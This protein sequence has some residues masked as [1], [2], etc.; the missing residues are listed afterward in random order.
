MQPS[1][2][3]LDI[4]SFWEYADP[5]LSEERFR[6]ALGSATGDR[7][8]ELVTQIARTYSLRGRF[9]EAHALLDEVERQ[10]A[11]AGQRPHIRYLL[12][13]GRTFNS[14]G[15]QEQ[16]RLLFAAAW[17]QAQAAGEEGLAVDAAHMLAITY[18]GTPDAIAWNQRGLD[19]ARSSTDHK[20]RALIP[21]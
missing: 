7:H 8:L 21:A 12:E 3:T 11:E 9:D 2:E 10:L 17:E 19:I 16:A 13:R 18:S 4:D 20:A 5:A 1:E 15:K 6:A 14:S